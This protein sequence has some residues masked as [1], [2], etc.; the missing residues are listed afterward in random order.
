MDDVEALLESLYVHCTIVPMK[1]THHE[2][3]TELLIGRN[4]DWVTLP[5]A[6]T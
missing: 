4:L 2:K 5:K 3:V 1:N 6:D